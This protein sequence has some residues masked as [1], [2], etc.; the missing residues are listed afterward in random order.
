[1]SLLNINFLNEAINEKD[2]EKP[3]EIFNYVRQEL[4][5]SISKEGQQDGF[6]GIL[7]C[8]NTKTKEITY[9]AANNKPLLVSGAEM[10]QLE[11]DKMPVGKS[12]K[13]G[14]FRLF[15]LTMKASETLY[16]YTDGYADQFG[17]PRGKKFKLNE[18][19]KL[20]QSIT[21]LSMTEQK[22]ML[23]KHFDLWKGD[24]EQVDDVLLFGIKV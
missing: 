19:N 7:L 1:M 23:K 4:I 10:K 8:I 21:H 5:D 6:D 14:V 24:L 17:G 9:S 20:L 3:N 18:L 13:E 16:L 2:L 12:V 15:N 11:T 22:L